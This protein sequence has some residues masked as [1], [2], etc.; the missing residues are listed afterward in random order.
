LQ[1]GKNFLISER[2]PYLQ[3]HFE[4]HRILD[5]FIGIVAILTNGFL[6]PNHGWVWLEDSLDIVVFLSKI[7]ETFLFLG[8]LR[9]FGFMLLTL[10]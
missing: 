6:L 9:A 1:N 4:S 7:V 5:T 8:D 2:R 3:R 10:L